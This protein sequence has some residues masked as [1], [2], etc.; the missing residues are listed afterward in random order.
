MMLTFIIIIFRI[1]MLIF[2]A[3][4]RF[5]FDRFYIWLDFFLSLN[6]LFPFPHRIKYYWCFLANS[7]PSS[8]AEIADIR[9]VLCIMYYQHLVIAI[10]RPCTIVSDESIINILKQYFCGESKRIYFNHFNPIDFVFQELVC[11]IQYLIFTLSANYS[12][13]SI[14]IH[15]WTLYQWNSLNALRMLG[16][17]NFHLFFHSWVQFSTPL[18]IRTFIHNDINA[19]EVIL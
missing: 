16:V 7:E 18:K 19:Y 9:Y 12:I 17:F 4:K 11:Y 10:K 8:A 6:L 2:V 15:H 14:R 5:F 3:I 1:W 13:R